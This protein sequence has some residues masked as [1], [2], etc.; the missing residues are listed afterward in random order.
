MR[1]PE[2]VK[3]ARCMLAGCVIAFVLASACTPS[4]EA[5]EAA[6]VSSFGTYTDEEAAVWDG[7]NRYSVYVPAKDGTRLA[8]DYFLPT[9]GGEE[10]TE[11]VP[12]VLHY[13]RYIRAIEGEDG[14]VRGREA[15]PVLRHLLKHGYAIAAA[16]ARGTGASFGVH[17]GAFSVEET[18]DSYAIIEWL[19]AQSWSNGKVGMSGRSYPGMTQYQAATQAPPALK[20]IC[21]E[22][23]GPSA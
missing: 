5:P 3:L 18:Q 2:R 1:V 12:V 23:A 9:R 21:P 13:T 4:A 15:D 6:Q 11:P 8:V 17:H 10:P 22:M 14:K 16:D 19:A 20:A 7:W